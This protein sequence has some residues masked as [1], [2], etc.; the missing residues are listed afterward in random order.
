MFLGEGHLPV[1]L[2][3][4]PLNAP[5]DQVFPARL[6]GRTEQ[7]G[8]QGRDLTWTGRTPD[9]EILLSCFRC[10]PVLWSS[11]VITGTTGLEFQP[12]YQQAATLLKCLSSPISTHTVS[13]NQ[14]H[15]Y[16]MGQI[17]RIG[18]TYTDLH[19]SHDVLTV[20]PPPPPP[21]LKVL[22]RGEALVRGHRRSLFDRDSSC[23]TDE[24]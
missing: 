12:L 5:P 2:Q 4:K 9:V 18:T 16:Q 8:V 6:H 1:I 7:A 17:V 22:S 20:E 24:T 14:Q 21:T 15:T 19:R 10:L 13:Y 23:H 3:V 11:G